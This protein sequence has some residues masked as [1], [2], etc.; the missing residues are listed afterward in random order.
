M[1][2]I[3]AVLAQDHSQKKLQGQDGKK[4]MKWNEGASCPTSFI[5]RYWP[6]C[7]CCANYKHYHVHL[8]QTFCKFFSSKCLMEVGLL[9]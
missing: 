1:M 7:S 9:L 4:P 2:L 5:G 3:Q 8:D 6:Y